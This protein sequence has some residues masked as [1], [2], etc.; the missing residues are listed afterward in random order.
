MTFWQGPTSHEAA[1]LTMTLLQPWPA[2]S[3]VRPA[4]GLP[5]LGTPTTGAAGRP[6]P[7]ERSLLDQRPALEAF[8]RRLHGGGADAEDLVQ[9]TLLK[10]LAARHQFTPGTRLKSW[11]FTIMRNTFNTRCRRAAVQP[12]SMGLDIES[13][14]ST[15][16]TQT[17]LLWSRQVIARLVNDLSPDHREVLI[18]IPVMG[19]SYE[20]VAAI[21]GCPVGT[22]KSRLSRARA[23]LAQLAGGTA[24]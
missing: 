15:P 4:L 24:P 16:A 7:F 12:Q 3:S 14:A 19:L 9:E 21:H 13:M 17:T 10:A 8:A 11:L 18:L 23:A 22:V 6:D 2:P 1:P 5:V 20:H